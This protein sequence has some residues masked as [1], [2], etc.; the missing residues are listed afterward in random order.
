MCGS[1]ETDT[2]LTVEFVEDLEDLVAELYVL[3]M[4]LAWD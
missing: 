1:R 4:L 3:R 2:G